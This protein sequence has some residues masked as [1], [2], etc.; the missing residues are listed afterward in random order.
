MA[1]ANSAIEG[2]S[3]PFVVLGFTT[4]CLYFFTRVNLLT[5]EAVC[6][7]FVLQ[8]TTI[9]AKC[10]HIASQPGTRYQFSKSEHFK[11]NYVRVSF[12]PLQHLISIYYLKCWPV[13]YLQYISDPWSPTI[14]LWPNFKLSWRVLQLTKNSVWTF[15]YHST[16][17]YIQVL[18]IL[19]SMISGTWENSAK[20]T[21][22][23]VSNLF[24]E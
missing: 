23:E 21:L 6:T 20:T 5:R 18:L 8:A 14:S 22:W 9:T 13:F 10:I 24:N 16:L 7:W 3:L 12:S 1:Q 15:C 17:Y 2:I 19:P 4:Y 11:V